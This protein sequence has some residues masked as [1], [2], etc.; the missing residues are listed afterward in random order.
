[1]VR[2]ANETTIDEVVS[3]R[4]SQEE[5]DVAENAQAI[6]Q[7]LCS[8]LAPSDRKR[9]LMRIIEANWMGDKR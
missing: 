8:G 6:L 9:V 3:G 5:E 4:L 1:M 2:G 7:G